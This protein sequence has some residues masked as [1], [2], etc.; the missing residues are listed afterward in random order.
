[1]KLTPKIVLIVLIVSLFGS[2]LEIW[3]GSWDITS[4]AIGAP[5]SFFTPPHAVLYSGVGI[6]L[7]AAIASLGI[8]V[9]DKEMRQ[10]SFSLGLKLILVGSMI[11]II[12]GPGDY[13]WHELF[14]TDGL[15]SPT[16]LTLITG[17]LIQSVGI[18]VGLTRLIPHNFKAV[19]P[20]LVIG[21]SALLFIV[22]AFI[23]QFSLPISNGETIN[24]NPD[25]YVAAIILASTM[26]FFCA[27]IFWGAAKSM[28][29]FGWASAS[30]AGLIILNVTANVIPNENLWVFLP[31]FAMP[32]I[33]AI[34]AD[35]IINKK[36]NLGKF[37]E[38][39]AGGITGAVFLVYSMPLVGM[40]YIQFYVFSGVSGYTLLPEFSETLAMVL[41]L[42]GIPGAIMGIIAVKIAKKKITIPVESTI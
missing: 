30:A 28:K 24:W 27:L 31:W 4:H 16:H 10:K 29:K 34:V 5:E 26:P 23:F 38:E 36:I 22:I 41:G 42:M 11:Q 12:A 20:A 6:S 17:I 9:K 19:K 13:L 21:F 37:G 1:M 32:M 8:I 33:V 18:I 39:I 40:A 35:A 2:V 7:V 25:S 3:G 15:L 14:G